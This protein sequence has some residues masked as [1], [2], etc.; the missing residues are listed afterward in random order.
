MNCD[1]SRPLLEAYLDDELD[2]VHSLAIEQHVESCADCLRRRDELLA[3][4][5]L[6]R[7]RLPRHAAP[8]ELVKRVRGA[9]PREAGVVVPFPTRWLAAA[10]VVAVAL[11]FLLVMRKSAPGRP[12]PLVAEAV[13]NHVRS[14]MADHLLDVESS[15]RHTVKPWIAEHVDYSPPVLD[16]ASTGYPL[17]GARLDYCGKRPIAALVYKCRKHTINVFVLPGSTPEAER[18]TSRDGFHVGIWCGSGMKFVIV[19]DLAEPDLRAFSDQFRDGV[20][21]L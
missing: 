9:L 21:K 2:L 18:W 6:I 7:H 4:R 12:D 15:D 10:A 19:S 16:F 5:D 17:A 3:L 14:L 20:H 8:A 13:S 1:E 11:A